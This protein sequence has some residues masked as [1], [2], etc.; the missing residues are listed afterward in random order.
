MSLPV[1]KI[2]EILEA[3]DV[4]FAGCTEKSELLA[5]L[6]ELR[7]NPAGLRQRQQQRRR[8]P[9]H[10]APPRQASGPRRR[11][12]AASAGGPSVA[13]PA[14]LGRDADGRDGG[15]T[16]V[17]I[18]RICA[19]DDYYEMLGVGRDADDAK[20]KQAYRKLALKLHPDKCALTG[21]EDA[22]KKV[23]AAHSCLTDERRRSVYD[24]FGT[25]RPEETGFG[26]G[27]G[28]HSVDVGVL[29]GQICARL[30][31]WLVVAGLS[32]ACRRGWSALQMGSAGRPPPPQ[33]GHAFRPAPPPPPPPPPPPA[34]PPRPPPPP[35]PT[36]LG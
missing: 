5:L 18:R 13:R 32:E 8:R 26:F 6:A 11:R 16:G 29:L 9:Q 35:P 24:T 12:Q 3:A 27:D 22:F 14:A 20:L 36:A 4:D 21:A 1:S 28:G 25:E 17:A 31:C 19:C 23:S 7:A 34:A 33:P 30:C 2:K 15:E 10:Q